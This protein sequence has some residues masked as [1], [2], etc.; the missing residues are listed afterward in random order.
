MFYRDFVGII[1]EL[2]S[3]CSKLICCQAERRHPEFATVYQNTLQRISADFSVLQV[4]LHDDAVA[5]LIAVLET[6]NAAVEKSKITA[7]STSK[8]QKRKFS[9][10]L[11]LASISSAANKSIRS[12]GLVLFISSNIDPCRLQEL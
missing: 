6:F 4:L 3:Q 12:K 2:Q 8:T 11:S 10:T 1:T 5:S 9:S 7:V